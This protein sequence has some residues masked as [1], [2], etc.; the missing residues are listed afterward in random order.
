MLADDA[1]ALAERFEF[2][3][4]PKSASWLNMIEIEFSA[5]SRL[6]L[7][8]RIPTLGQLEKE[9]LTLVAERDAKEIKIDWQF[10]TRSARSMPN[11]HYAAIL[12]DNKQFK[13]S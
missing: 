8:H 13:D 3:F 12:D 7:H 2:Y 6:C 1:K 10:S 9:I 4:T 5:L 11:P